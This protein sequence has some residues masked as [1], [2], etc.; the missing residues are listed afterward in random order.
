MEL[1]RLAVH[2]R[3]AEEVAQTA[4][5]GPG[6]VN[7]GCDQH[8]QHIQYPYAQVL[9]A[10]AGKNN[11]QPVRTATLPVPERE[12]F[13]AHTQIMIHKPAPCFFRLA[14]SAMRR[15]DATPVADI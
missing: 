6:V 2:Q 1:Q 9:A 14:L 7:S 8:Q 10:R 3:V 15:A 5:F 13:S 4:R 11:V 12:R